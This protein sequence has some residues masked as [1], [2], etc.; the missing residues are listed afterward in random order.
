MKTKINWVT[1]DIASTWKEGSV[2]LI[3]RPNLNNKHDGYYQV[4]QYFRP[5][6]VKNNDYYYEQ[7]D[8]TLYFLLESV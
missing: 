7:G 4:C 1:K 6:W 8:V 3:H 5:D 2:V